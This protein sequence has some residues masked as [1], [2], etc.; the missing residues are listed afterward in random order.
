MRYR[1]LCTRSHALN[2]VLV[3]R[4]NGHGGNNI[5]LMNKVS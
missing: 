1:D 4:K 2:D 3:K 5:M